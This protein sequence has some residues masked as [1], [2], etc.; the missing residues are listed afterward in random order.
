[1][2]KTMLILAVMC[3]FALITF[4]GTSA[5][6]NHTTYNHGSGY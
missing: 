6:T 4:T 5:P 2:K 1:M 3:S